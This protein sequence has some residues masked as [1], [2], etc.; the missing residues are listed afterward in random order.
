MPAR[1][2]FFTRVNLLPQD[3]F[4]RSFVGKTLRWSL[5]AGKSIVILTEF[6]VILAFLS[7]FKLDRDLNDLN[8]EVIYKQAVVESYAATED[9]MRALQDRL[10]VID[11]ADSDTLGASEALVK[12]MANTPLDVRYERVDLSRTSMT[13]I[14][15]AGSERGFA[16]LLNSI[17]Q[18]GDWTQISLGDIEFSQRQGG[19]IFT[20]NGKVSVNNKTQGGIGTNE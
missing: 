9:E 16:A 8:E 3:D 4:E 14:G 12:L 13:L 18:S 11:Q 17:R 19:V 1:G 7:R 20:I 6:V 5:S 10:D 15:M 2:S